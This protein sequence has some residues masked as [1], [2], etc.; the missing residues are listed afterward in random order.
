MLYY[1]DTTSPRRTTVRGNYIHQC[2]WITKLYRSHEP[3]GQ[4]TNTDGRD[5][6]RLP[7][8]ILIINSDG[9]TRRELT[10]V[11]ETNPA[12]A[13]MSDHIAT[14]NQ[15]ELTRVSRQVRKD[16]LPI[17]YGHH[18]FV[19]RVTAGNV[20][21]SV[22]KLLDWL[23]TLGPT[24]A[25]MIRRLVLVYLRKKNLRY[26]TVKLLPELRRRGLDTAVLRY[27]RMGHP[28]QLNELAVL[29]G[30][31]DKRGVRTWW[32]CLVY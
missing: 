5:K 12:C 15:P 26:F 17:F 4:L 23:D 10:K 2:P 3:H 28:F 21:A 11:R 6:L 13:F 16:T 30:L 8:A 18:P 9:E 27:E 19:Y 22:Q 7:A 14:V 20:Q 25:A 24:N 29:K 1:E 31:Y 32:K